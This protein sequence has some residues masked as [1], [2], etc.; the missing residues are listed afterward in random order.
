M[1]CALPP[2]IKLSGIAQPV[3]LRER[4]NA[5]RVTLSVNR[6]TRTATITAPPG[7]S[8]SRIIAF[9]ENHRDWLRTRLEMVPEARPF[10]FGMTLPYR[11]TP[12]QVAPGTG[13]GV[14]LHGDVIEVAATPLT[15][16]VKLGRWLRM[17]ARDR[18]VERSL[19]HADKLG[20]RYSKLSI[21]D[22]T[23][24][25]GSCS[26][27]GA[28]SYSWR[29]I[30]APDEA[31]DYLAAHEVCHLREMNHSPRFWALVEELCPEWQEWRNWFR[32][33]GAELHRYGAQ[34]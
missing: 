6:A 9:A 3:R 2:D 15:L 18:L 19:F 33:N 20:V 1:G 24:R 8:L 16:D 25:W 22:T 4:S 17:Q 21:K 7:I 28:L 5:R 29:A 13:R 30:L 34:D 26:S 10:E 14:L 31:L 12:C 32:E 11:G 27:Q 23:S